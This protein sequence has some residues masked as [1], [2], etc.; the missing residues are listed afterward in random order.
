LASTVGNHEYYNRNIDTLNDELKA[1]CIDSNVQV[2]QNDTCVIK[3]VRFIGSTLWTDFDLYGD[4]RGHAAEG[5]MNMNDYRVIATNRGGAAKPSDT[6]SRHMTSR[7]YLERTLAQPFD[8]PTVVIAH[9]AP[10]ARSVAPRYKGD[11]LSPCFASNMEDLVV[12]SRAVV[13]IHG[14]VHDTFDYTL[15]E[16]RVVCNPKGYVGEEKER[17]SPPV[18]LGLHRGSGTLVATLMP[19]NRTSL[20]SPLRVDTLQPANVR[21]QIGL[22]L[23]PGKQCPSQFGTTWRRDLAT[24]LDAIHEW[25]AAAL[26]TVMELKEMQFLGVAELGSAARKVGL[27]WIHLPVEDGGVP[28]R[29]FDDAWPAAS[30]SL[31]EDLMQGRNVVIHC[32]G[33]LGRTG[34]VASLLLVELG[35]PP[36]DALVCVR[37]ARPGAVETADQ[38]A[39]VRT[40]RPGYRVPTQPRK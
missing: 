4:A 22:T 28:D 30:R 11:L 37:A 15:G 5:W 21:G 13:W 25:G 34:L 6:L 23:C 31:L 35:I 14:H 27:R 39:Y 2:L 9:H 32:R 24:D 18:P 7:A 10:S 16:T 29:R 12:R 38:E 17:E 20:S 19:H 33:G 3:G 8:G 26:V 40:Y 36:A 1:N